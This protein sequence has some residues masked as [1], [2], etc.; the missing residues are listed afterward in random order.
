MIKID[1]CIYAWFDEDCYIIEV[2]KTG[3]LILIFSL[4]NNS[5]AIK[6]R[7]DWIPK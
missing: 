4:F 7:V 1:Y 2:C 3:P 6:I 5:Y